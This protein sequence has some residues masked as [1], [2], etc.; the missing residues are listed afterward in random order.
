MISNR[1]RARQYYVAFCLFLVLSAGWVTFALVSQ[2]ESLIAQDTKSRVE[3]YS[4][5]FEDH[6]EKIFSTVNW[7]NDAAARA[8][9]YHGDDKNRLRDELARIASRDP[10]VLQVSI[11]DSKGIFLTSN[12]STEPADLRDREHI[13]VHLN[14]PD[15]GI[16][17]SKPLVGRVS[18]KQSINVTSRLVSRSSTGIL[19]VSFAPDRLSAFFKQSRMGADGSVAIFRMDGVLLA[20]SSGENVGNNYF[21]TLEFGRMLLHREGILESSVTLGGATK[22]YSFRVLDALPL[23]LM[24]GESIEAKRTEVQ[25]LHRMAWAW[26]FGLVGTLVIGGGLLELFVRQQERTHKAQMSKVRM[27]QT[28]ELLQT[29]FSMA[30]VHIIVWEPPHRILYASAADISGREFLDLLM[31]ERVVHQNQART[32]FVNRIIDLDGERRSYSWVTVPAMWVSGTAMVAVGFDRTELEF[33]EHALYQRA[34]LTTMGE[35][36]TSLSHEI[37]QP[38]TAINFSASAIADRAVE[39]HEMREAVDLLTSAVARVK[40][41]VDRMKM[42]GRLGDGQKVE[43]IDLYECAESVAALVRNELSL[44]RIEIVQLVPGEMLGYGD[45]LLF[46]QVLLNL[47]LNARDAI[48]ASGGLPEH[49]RSVIISLNEVKEHSVEL[50]VSDRGFGV[51]IDIRDRI[52][53]PFFTTKSKGTGLG[54]ALSFGIMRDMGGDIVLAPTDEGAC[55]KLSLPRPPKPGNKS[56][57]AEHAAGVSS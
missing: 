18:G 56:P 16:F 37:A 55:F 31:K 14:N 7:M 20:N 50:C 42:F 17:I 12:V 49:R 46:E 9:E 29:A 34:R 57:V 4:R 6:V 39:A 41:I 28:I 22:T 1:M 33:R 30:G 54:L 45:A 2:I 10:F 24:V 15:A 13:S 21:D 38:L 48:V 3:H 32:Q 43:A 47:V 51:P 11:V 25:L 26:S 35:M 53:D 40:G 5:L 44:D 8:L 19:V 36:L 52:F 23:V 27:Q